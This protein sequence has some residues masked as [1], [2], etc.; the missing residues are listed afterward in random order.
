MDE[1]FYSAQ[2]K[3]SAHRATLVQVYNDQEMDFVISLLNST[4]GHV[5]HTN[6]DKYK[7]A[8]SLLP[9]YYLSLV[10]H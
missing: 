5:N 6:N 1:T 8:K 2:E 7:S 3:C 10:I 4:S 9:H